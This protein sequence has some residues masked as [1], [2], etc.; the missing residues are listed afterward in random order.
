[1]KRWEEKLM[2]RSKLM[3]SG[4]RQKI[5]RWQRKNI[6]WHQEKEGEKTGDKLRIIK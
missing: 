4:W 3:K 5:E 2:R 6:R 1:M